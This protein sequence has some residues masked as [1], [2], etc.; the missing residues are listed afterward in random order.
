MTRKRYLFGGRESAEIAYRKAEH[1]RL[2]QLRFGRCLLMG[3]GFIS[4]ICVCK[5]Y[6]VAMFDCHTAG[7]PKI[8]WVFWPNSRKAPGHGGQEPDVTVFGLLDTE[9]PKHKR[10]TALV[11]ES[12]EGYETKQVIACL[13]AWE[14]ARVSYMNRPV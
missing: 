9:S 5:D 6:R 2:V 13:D 10:E 1:E 8:A 14:A 12:R 3:P 7:E 11:Y 4:W